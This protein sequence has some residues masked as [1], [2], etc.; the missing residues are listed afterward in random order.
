[1][2]ERQR[3]GRPSAA[4]EEATDEA[5]GANL[6]DVR[7]LADSLMANAQSSLRRLGLGNA[8]DFM[9]ATRQSGG[10]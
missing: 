8:N 3:S 7:T 2:T 6:D 9:N 1:M 10:Q 4:T 5:E